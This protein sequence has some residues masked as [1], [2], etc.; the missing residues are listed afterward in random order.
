M[1]MVMVM[2]MVIVIA[3][4]MLIRMLML[5]VSFSSLFFSFLKEQVHVLSL[6]LPGTPRR[7]LCSYL[8]LIKRAVIM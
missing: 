1:V 6:V 5:I 3:I 7:L 8:L 2:V 4:A